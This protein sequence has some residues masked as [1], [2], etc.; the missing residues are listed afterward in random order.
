MVHD[1]YRDVWD[2]LRDE[3]T[4]ILEDCEA[5][6]ILNLRFA[7]TEPQDNIEVEEGET[8]LQTFFTKSVKNVVK[9]IVEKFKAGS[10]MELKRERGEVTLFLQSSGRLITDDLRSMVREL[11]GG[12]GY[13]LEYIEGEIRMDEDI[14]ALFYGSPSKLIFILPSADGRKLQILET[15][16]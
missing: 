13:V 16:L 6:L 12:Q 5:I 15:S 7:S 2:I 9:K 10:H 14:S 3:I 1:S 8:Y 4:R 11:V